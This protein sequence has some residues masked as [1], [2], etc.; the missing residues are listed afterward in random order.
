MKSCKYC[1]CTMQI[2]GIYYGLHDEAHSIGYHCKPCGSDE[3]TSWATAREPEKAEAR[4]AELMDKEL[5]GMAQ[6]GML[7]G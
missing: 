2:T 6:M 7:A 5:A 1:G 3:S 4:Q